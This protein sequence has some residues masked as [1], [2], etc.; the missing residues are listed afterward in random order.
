MPQETVRTLTVEGLSF[1]YRM[2]RQG[3]SR[4]EPLVALGGVFQGMYDWPQMEDALTG[5]TSLV[6]ANLPDSGDA[7]PLPAG[8]GIDTLCAALE[9]VIDGLQT[10]RVNLYGYSYGASIAFRYAQRHPERCA[11]LL[12]GGVPSHITEAQFDRSRASHRLLSAGDVD[13]FVNTMAAEFFCLD[14]NRYVHRRDLALSYFRRTLLRATDRRDIDDALVRAFGTRTE[15]AGGLTGVPTL[16]F[17]GEHDTVTTPEQQRAFAT[18]IEGSR[19][20]TIP[21]ADHMLLM[22]R[23]ETVIS[24]VT[25][26]IT[27]SRLQPAASTTHER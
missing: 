22:E 4:T 8:H 2:L 9:A 12:L 25:S 11:R 15:L 5:L 27:D 23:P 3:T 19:F 17:C 21:D 20:V 14:E 13:G 18:T 6:T 16:V 24:L 10:P 26:F 7:D 1:P